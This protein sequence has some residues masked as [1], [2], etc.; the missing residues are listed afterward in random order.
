[1]I[2]GNY[3]VL[4]KNPSRSTGGLSFKGSLAPYD[5]QYNFYVSDA[6]NGQLKYASSPTATQPPYSYVL[7]PK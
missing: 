3:S 6:D 2:L 4:N 7:A 1:M 5:S